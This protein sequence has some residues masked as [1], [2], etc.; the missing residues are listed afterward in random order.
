MGGMVFHPEL[1]LDHLGDTLAR[2]ERA[3]E[4]PRLGTPSEERGHR[5]LLLGREAG[6]TAG[7]LAVVQGGFA[8]FASAGEPLADGAVGNAE[9]RRNLDDLPALLEESPGAEAAALTPS[10]RFIC[11]VAGHKGFL[12]IASECHSTTHGSVR[13]SDEDIRQPT[14]RLS[15]TGRGEMAVSSRPF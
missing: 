14:L 11:R 13:T 2:P 15:G 10:G 6:H 3:A 4:A 12:P 1:A 5:L 7:P 8:L 9:R